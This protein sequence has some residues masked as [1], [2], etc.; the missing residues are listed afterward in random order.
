MQSLSRSESGPVMS[1]GA[2]R[3]IGHLYTYL[4]IWKDS[5]LPSSTLDIHHVTTPLLIASQ[6]ASPTITQSVVLYLS[7]SSFWRN[8]FLSCHKASG[9]SPALCWIREHPTAGRRHDTSPA[10]QGETD[11]L[12]LHGYTHK[13]SLQT[14]AK[15]SFHLTIVKWKAFKCIKTLFVNRY[16]FSRTAVL[17]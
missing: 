13:I 3:V 6:T 1:G 16:W 10:A 14:S 7:K 12:W 11:R 2:V 9:Q 8:Y 15:S 4:I 5:N 17:F